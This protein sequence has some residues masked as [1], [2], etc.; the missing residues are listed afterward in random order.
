M[1]RAR[2]CVTSP[3]STREV[4]VC[5]R[6]VRFCVW[7]RYVNTQTL[8]GSVDVCRISVAQLACTCGVVDLPA[9]LVTFGEVETMMD[10]S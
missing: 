10:Q 2:F 9:G 7:V 5:Y 3:N 4:C 1:C 6:N 8:R